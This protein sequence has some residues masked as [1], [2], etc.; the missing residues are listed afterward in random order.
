M[1]S[2]KII[3]VGDLHGDFKVFVNVLLMC[4]LIDSN[5]SW[6]GRDTYLVQL[7]DTL[8]GKRP[9]TKIDRD[10]QQL[11]RPGWQNIFYVRGAKADK[12]HYLT[13]Y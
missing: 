11:S 1:F 10:F 13:V 2:N 7:G 6:I 5:L 3:A 12:S 9:D 8:D 4:N